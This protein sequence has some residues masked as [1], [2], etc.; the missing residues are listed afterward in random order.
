MAALEHHRG[1][2]LNERHGV[3]M[4]VS[5]HGVASPTTDD[6]DDVWILTSEEEGHCAAASEGPGAYVVG[7]DTGV[8]WDREGC[9]PEEAGDQCGCYVSFSAVHVEE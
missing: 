2:V 6:S 5:E 7:I 9:C 1:I 4:E 3:G 8:P